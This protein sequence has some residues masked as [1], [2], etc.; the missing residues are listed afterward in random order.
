M[1]DRSEIE[2]VCSSVHP[3]HEHAM[4]M[5]G[6]CSQLQAPSLISTQAGN[7]SLQ[8]PSS[9]VLLD[10]PNQRKRK[11]HTKR[12]MQSLPHCTA[13]GTTVLEKKSRTQTPT[14][15]REHPVQH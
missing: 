5:S 11:F 4:S 2:S 10:Q 1:D 12:S 6:T 15:P 13:S 8:V 14:T 9:T 7:P 3:D